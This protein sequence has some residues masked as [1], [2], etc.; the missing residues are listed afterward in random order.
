MVVWGVYP[1]D[2]QKERGVSIECMTTTSLWTRPLCVLETCWVLQI[3]RGGGEGE[4]QRQASDDDDDAPS[5]EEAHVLAKL[6]LTHPHATQPTQPHVPVPRRPGWLVT[7]AWPGPRHSPTISP[8]P[9][10]SASPSHPRL[11]P[12]H[13]ALRPCPAPKYGAAPAI[14]RCGSGHVFFSPAT[15]RRLSESRF[16]SPALKSGR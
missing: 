16:L 6:L 5:V 1:C 2:W 11:P 10:V 3:D 8:C 13:P 15:S 9:S 14:P 12:P 4:R 7:W